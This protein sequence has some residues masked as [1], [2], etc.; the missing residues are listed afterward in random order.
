MSNKI[1][2]GL[3][4]LA[5]IVIGY[6]AFNPRLAQEAQPIAIGAIFSLTGNGAAYGEPMRDGAVLAVEEINRNGGV[7]GR[8]LRLVLED[9]QFDA[10]TAVSAYQSLKA[11]GVGFFL[12]NGSSVSLAL[13]PL[14][15]ADHT[16]LFETGAVTPKY[17]DGSPYTCRMTLTAVPAAVA[18]AN[19]AADTLHA[20][21]VASLTLNDDY[22][23]AMKDAF[24]EAV[25]ARGL[26]VTLEDAIPKDEKD[27]RTYISRL[28]AK[29]SEIDVLM[30]IPIASHIEPTL[31]QLQELGWK[32]PILSDNYTIINPSLKTSALAEGVYFSNYD[33]SIAGNANDATRRASFKKDFAQ[34]FG[35]NPSAL[36]ANGYDEINMLVQAMRDIKSDAPQK[37]VDYLTHDL[38]TFVGVSGDLTLN[39]DCESPRKAVIN[40]V[41]A[42]AYVRVGE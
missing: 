14:V 19:F 32:K 23:V 39:S 7:N 25:E 5:A 15:R 24:R 37:V 42:G 11:R 30:L 17:S 13:S 4:V 40:Q 12:S 22:G 18:L 33:W 34:K 38:G 2:I 8:Q 36:S 9:S 20:K 41:S 35:E 16:L 6:F 3:I 31:R 27:T 26:T 10:K 1:L 29:E 28:K 21:K